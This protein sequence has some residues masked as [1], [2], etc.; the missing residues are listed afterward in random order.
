MKLDENVPSNLTWVAKY[1]LYPLKRPMPKTIV[2]SDVL[3]M[4]KTIEVPPLKEGYRYRIVVE[5]SIHD[6]SG[7]GFAIYVNGKLL[8]ENKEGV[9]GWRKQGIRG[10]LLKNEGLEAF[11]GGKVTIAVSNF[12]MSNWKPDHF[13]PFFR[14]LSVW[15]EEQKIPELQ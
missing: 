5:G 10:V 15:V 7:E 2:E 11:K 12:P 14:P 8:A 4:R 9:T 13:I 3:L 6:N 1:P